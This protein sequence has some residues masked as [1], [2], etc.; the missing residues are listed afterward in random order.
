M[1]LALGL[2]AISALCFDSPS[3]V[4][5]L[6]GK[7]APLA[8]IIEKHGAKLDVD[9]APFWLALVTEKGDVHPLIKDDHARIFFQDPRMLNRAVRI[10]ARRLPRTD[11]LQVLE[12]NTQVNGKLNEV[13]YWCDICAIRRAALPK[14]CECCGGPMELREVPIS[15]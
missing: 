9:A 12:V 3:K 8:E 10:G 15:K 6:T 13:Y 2:L 1:T 7:V 11:F 14:Q 5:Y 4:D